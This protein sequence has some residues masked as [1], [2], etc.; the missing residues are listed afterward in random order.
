MQKLLQITAY[1]NTRKVHQKFIHFKSRLD[2]SQFLPFTKSQ[3]STLFFFFFFYKPELS[4]YQIK[5]NS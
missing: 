3:Y 1:L 5:F 4:L 2:P